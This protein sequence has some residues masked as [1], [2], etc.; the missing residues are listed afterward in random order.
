MLP[1][2]AREYGQTSSC[3]ILTSSSISAFGRSGTETSSSTASSKK[4]LSF[5][6]IVT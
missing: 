3:A 6:P 1:R 4:P 2:V 5:R